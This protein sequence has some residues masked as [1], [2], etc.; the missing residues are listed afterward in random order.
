M[1]MAVAR[2][3]SRC[4]QASCGIAWL[5]PWN[6]LKKRLLSYVELPVPEWHCPSSEKQKVGFGLKE[7]WVL[8]AWMALAGIELGKMAGPVGW[9]L[10]KW[11]WIIQGEVHQKRLRLHYQGGSQNGLQEDCKWLC[12]RDRAGLFDNNLVIQAEQRWK[13]LNFW[14]LHSVFTQSWSGDLVR[15]CGYDRGIWAEEDDVERLEH[16]AEAN[17]GAREP[18]VTFSIP[19]RE[20]NSVSKLRRSWWEERLLLLVCDNCWQVLA[21]QVRCCWLLSLGASPGGCLF[22]F[23]LQERILVI[24]DLQGWDCKKTA[25]TFLFIYTV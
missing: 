14:A 10:P 13:Y 7:A 1:S 19:R 15:Q 20:R 4:S 8:T 25:Q 5:M 9:R 18:S 2:A 24:I 21:C 6:P 22:P 23:Q 12:F 11:K 3:V 17:Q 16:G